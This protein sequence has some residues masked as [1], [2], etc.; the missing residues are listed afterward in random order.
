M[1]LLKHWSIIIKQ[2]LAQQ[3]RIQVPNFPHP[4]SHDVVFFAQLHCHYMAQGC[5]FADD[6]VKSAV[7]KDICTGDHFLLVGCHWQYLA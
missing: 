1:V 6:E 2:I 3:L 5:A 4:M 7:F